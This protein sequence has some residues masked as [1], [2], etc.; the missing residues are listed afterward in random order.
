MREYIWQVMHDAD[1]HVRYYGGLQKRYEWWG[2]LTRGS[3]LFLSLA[4][5]SDAKKFIE[6]SEIGFSFLLGLAVTL[7]FVMGFDKKATAA[8]IASS[9]CDFLLHNLRSLWIEVYPKPKDFYDE[10][11]Q[12]K[13]RHDQRRTICH[14]S[15]H[16]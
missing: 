5:I 4:V 11:I 7:D 10:H 2:R 6:Y 16:I 13:T 15:R 12:E 1:R 14:P 3:I 9:R 8:G